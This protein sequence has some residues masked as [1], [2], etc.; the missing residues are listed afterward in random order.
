MKNSRMCGRRGC[1]NGAIKK[2]SGGPCPSCLRYIRA[3]LMY[4]GDELSTKVIAANLGVG[5]N[6]VC[7]MLRRINYYIRQSA[8]I[9]KLTNQI[10]SE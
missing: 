10:R 2:G 9:L 3:W 5:R 6:R 4:Y 1:V 8:V 7:Q